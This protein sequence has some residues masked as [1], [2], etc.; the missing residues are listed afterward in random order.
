[1]GPLLTTQPTPGSTPELQSW[2]NRRKKAGTP[3][4]SSLYHPQSRS[5]K[6]K[7]PEEETA[8]RKPVVT[9]TAAIGAV[10]DGFKVKREP[11]RTAEKGKLREAGL[12]TGEGEASISE[13]QQDYKPL[14]TIQFSGENQTGWRG[15]KCREKINVGVEEKFRI[16]KNNSGDFSPTRLLLFSCCSVSV[17]GEQQSHTL[18]DCKEIDTQAVCNEAIFHIPTIS[19]D[20]CLATTVQDEAKSQIP[21]GSNVVDSNSTT[22][23]NEDNYEI[24]AICGV[25]SFFNGEANSLMPML[26]DELKPHSPMDYNEVTTVSMA[27]I[28]LSPECSSMLNLIITAQTD[29][30]QFPTLVSKGVNATTSSRSGRVQFQTLQL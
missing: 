12:L 13:I 15:K 21:A 25:D 7:T 10:T 1:M 4:K 11:E 23:C 27:E 30:V 19:D 26:S 3:S 24:P 18:A 5:K 16:L 28:T 17:G 22:V 14:D 9:E 6:P 29:K 8:A 20:E 2:L